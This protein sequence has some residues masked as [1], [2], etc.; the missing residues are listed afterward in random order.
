MT[1]GLQVVIPPRGWNALNFLRPKVEAFIDTISFTFSAQYCDVEST[2]LM[3]LLLSHQLKGILGYGIV[4]E[5]APLRHYKHTYVLSVEDIERNWGMAC[6]GGHTQKNTILVQI[7]G[8]GCAAAARGWEQRLFDW[9]QE[10]PRVIVTRIDLAIDT[11]NY[12]IKQAEQDWEAGKF[13]LNRRMPRHQRHNYDNP[14]EGRTLYIGSRSGGKYTRI[15]EKGKQLGDPDSSLIR[16]ETEWRN[17]HRVLPQEML[18]KPTQYLAGAYPAT[19]DIIEYAE[20]LRVPTQVKALKTSY[21]KVI[22]TIRH[23]FG[24]YI[25]TMRQFESPETIIEKLSR[26]AK[27]K[28]GIPE[29]L[30]LP[31]WSTNASQKKTKE[32]LQDGQTD[33]IEMI[34]DNH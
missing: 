28:T 21:E 4:K 14:K 27:N 2:S 12:S 34:T 9:M 16:V 22:Q 6:L 8:E 31:H 15:Y 24:A 20:P 23:Q 13:S 17:K 25:H 7:Y 11:E 18:I 30:L 26:P 33:W 3:A 10:L 29:R 1:E 19:A 5:R 32:I